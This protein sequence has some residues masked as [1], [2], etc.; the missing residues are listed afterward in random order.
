MRAAW[1]GLLLLLLVVAS[2]SVTGYTIGGAGSSSFRV[3]IGY[4]NH[5]EGPAAYLELVALPQALQTVDAMELAVMP[6]RAMPIACPLPPAG[7][8]PS[9][10]GFDMTRPDNASFAFAVQ[11]DFLWLPPDESVFQPKGLDLYVCNTTA[12]TWLKA[13]DHDCARFGV[14][15]VPHPP[16]TLLY[17]QTFICHA[18]PFM[19]FQNECDQDKNGLPRTCSICVSGQRGCWCEI[20]ADNA[21]EANH[22]Y[23]ALLVT[24]AVLFWA[25]TFCRA[26]FLQAIAKSTAGVT[27]KTQT[28]NIPVLRELLSCFVG[29]STPDMEVTRVVSVVL[30]LFAMVIAIARVYEGHN[31]RCRGGGG[32]VGHAR[33]GPGSLGEPWA[34]SL[35]QNVPLQVLPHGG[36]HQRQRYH[37]AHRVAQPHPGGGVPGHAGGV[38]GVL[39]PGLVHC[40]LVQGPQPLAHRACCVCGP[41]GLLPVPVLATGTHGSP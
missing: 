1:L 5:S 41:H 18:T 38:A 7:M 30:Y 35:L 13:R 19:L 23:Q 36:G 16:T 20:K 9:G 37:P 40:R 8:V 12:G 17:L 39:R 11:V 10:P 27:D 22:T 31:D 28:T 3:P 25:A 4:V 15:A 29:K 24:M 2:V 33:H 14:P 32:G 6:S 26:F 21:W 34:R